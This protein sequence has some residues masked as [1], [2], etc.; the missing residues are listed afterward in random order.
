MSV[1]PLVVMGLYKCYT[2]ISRCR[3]LNE[4][5]VKYVRLTPS[6][7][8]EDEFAVQ[9]FWCPEAFC[10]W[11]VRTHFYQSDILHYLKEYLKKNIV[12]I[13]SNLALTKHFLHSRMKLI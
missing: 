13:S 7:L 10:F 12:G 11:V 1:K 8:Q 2:T 5:P 6:W 4:K 3:F 9:V